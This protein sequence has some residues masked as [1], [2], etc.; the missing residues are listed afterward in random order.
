[1]RSTH[2][3]FLLP[4]LLA[5]GCATPPPAGPPPVWAFASATMT[6]GKELRMRSEGRYIQVSVEGNNIFGPN[7]SLTH[8]ADFIRG[9]GPGKVA[10][11][12]TLKGTHA[13]G[14]IKNAPLTVDLQPRGDG[15][16]YVSGLFGGSLSQFSIS[17][18]I[19]Q[20]KLGSCSYDLK[21]NG[22]RYEGSSSCNGL[23]SL[24]SVEFPAAM[25][26]WSDLEVA[27]VLAIVFGT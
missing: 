13:E 8:G 22:T 17:P 11:Q 2:S 9:F 12:I 27:T 1:M 25:A 3:L 10:V 19:F 6:A 15:V 24:T 4:L 26:A 7:W 21:Y 20:G 5:L 14:N 16:T 18:A 23:I